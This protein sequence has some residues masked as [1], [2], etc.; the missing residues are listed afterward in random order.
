MLDH[1]CTQSRMICTT[2]QRTSAHFR[3]EFQTI[4]AAAEDALS[5]QAALYEFLSPPRQYE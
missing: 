2:W 1:C 3:Q 5:F 4:V